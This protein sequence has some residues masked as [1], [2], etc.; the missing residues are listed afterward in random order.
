MKSLYQLQQFS[1]YKLTYELAQKYV[2]DICTALDLIPEV[3]R[4]N[5]EQILASKKGD[6]VLYSKW[7]H[8]LIALTEQ[9]EFAGVVIGYE[10][11]SE[12]NEQYPENCIYL[13]DLAV[14]ANYQKKGLGKFIVQ[15]W[16]DFNTKTGFLDLDGQLRFCVQ[17][18]SSDW[19]VHV[20]RL[21]ESFGF[22]KIS[23]KLYG[24]RE[25]NVYVLQPSYIIRHQ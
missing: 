23:S 4:H 5:P 9:G 8:S 7:Q 6:R 3:D 10:R 12:G 11:K 21:Y 25:D 24:N 20:Q 18:N 16:L 14:A 15:S 13:N 2:A 1:I 17:T 19:N 22:T